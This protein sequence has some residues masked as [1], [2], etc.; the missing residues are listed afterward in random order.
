VA[1]SLLTAP[2]GSVDLVQPP[3]GYDLLCP[4]FQKLAIRLEV[5]DP[6][7]THYILARSE[8]FETDVKLLR[9]RFHELADAPRLDEGL[10]FPDRKMVND[11]LTFN[12]AFRQYVTSRQSVDRVHAEELQIAL[13]EADRLYQI[14]DAVRDARCNYYYVKV[15]R[16]AL[17]RLRAMIGVPA[18]YRGELPP[19]VPIWR[20]PEID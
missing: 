3:A 15:R 6:R 13:N 10:R 11:L 14:W 8:D 18:F 9:C 12:R 16:Q 1:L 7:E 17:K 2:K 5:L 4:T 19:H 20:F